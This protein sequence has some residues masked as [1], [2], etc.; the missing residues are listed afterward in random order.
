MPGLEQKLYQLIIS[1]LDGEN[2]SS[3]AYAERT[4]ELVEKGIGGFIIFGGEKAEVKTF[5]NKLQSIAHPPCLSR[6]I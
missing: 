3:P 6:P 4:L 1:R 2:I 5:I